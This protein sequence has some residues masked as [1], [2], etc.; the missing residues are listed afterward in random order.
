MSFTSPFF[1]SAVIDEQK[2][3]WVSSLRGVNCCPLFHIIF[4]LTILSLRLLTF[5]ASFVLAFLKSKKY[6]KCEAKESVNA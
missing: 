4:A 6:M 5:S 3:T 2:S 1:K